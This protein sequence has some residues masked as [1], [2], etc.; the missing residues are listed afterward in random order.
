MKHRLGAA[1][2]CAVLASIAS[3]EN[4]PAPEAPP[5]AVNTPGRETFAIDYVVTFRPGESGVARVRWELSG[6]EE[7][8]G[9]KFKAPRDRFSD[10]R[11]SGEI[12]IED[13][14]VEWEPHGPYAHLEYKVKVDHRRGD[15]GHFDSY[16]TRDWVLFRARD[17]FPPVRVSYE[18]R[19][20]GTR[21]RSRARL[22]FRLPDDWKSAAA[23]PSIAPDVYSLTTGKVLSRPS[24]WIAL[25]KL[26]RTHQE[27]D[28]VMVQIAEA[29]E[30]KLPSDDVFAMLTDAL[31]RLRKIFRRMPPQILIVSAGDPMWRGGLSAYH[32][33]FLHGDRPLRTP[34]KTSP[35]L[36]ELFHVVQPFR[37]RAN[38]DWIVEGLAE[39]YSLELQRRS[40]ALTAGGFSKGLGY[41]AKYGMWNVDLTKQTDNAATNN[42]APLVMYA[43]DQRIQRETAGK[44]SL[45]DVVTVLAEKGGW[46]DTESF[47]G[48][49][50]KV[51]GKPFDKFFHRYVEEGEMPRLEGEGKAPS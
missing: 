14:V 49:V 31:P 38:A 4:T 51:S 50:D 39:Y 22:V 24:G 47:R 11:G 17:L 36:H 32:S 23:H 46:V 6:A 7:I 3:A 42:S 28:E 2:L 10:I 30:A 41:F 25:G 33:L 34:D 37:G 21:P 40:G 18:T 12:E 15:K 27:I 5:T 19:K 44:K 35:V 20:E 43:L 8:D 13:G 9:L 48:A 45:D 26:K 16:S 1:F 29:P